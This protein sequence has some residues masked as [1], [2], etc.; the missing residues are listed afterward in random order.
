MET[1]Y[2]TVALLI[3]GDHAFFLT[4]AAKRAAA[5]Q[6][7]EAPKAKSQEV[8]ASISRRATSTPGAVFWELY[9]VLKP[10][11]FYSGKLAEVRADFHREGMCPKVRLSG[12][13]QLK[14]LVWNDCVVH[15]LP[16]ETGVC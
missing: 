12:T 6:I 3:W 14:Q 10:G 5:K 13:G 11:H 1:N 8:M 16:R 7:V 15:S 4:D 9:T 2:E